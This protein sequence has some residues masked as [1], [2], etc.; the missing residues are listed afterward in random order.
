MNKTTRRGFIQQAATTIAGLALC[1]ST[2]LAK[3]RPIK[4]A[5]Y[6]PSHCAL[7][8]VHAYYSD[9]YKKNGVHAEIV[10]CAGMPEV[11]QK[12]ISGQVDFAQVMTPM[13][14]KMHFSQMNLPLVITQTLGTN[15]GALGVA[16]QS[17]I[18]KI[19][20]LNGKRIGI[21][22]PLMIHHLILRLILE[23]YGLTK[24]NIQIVTVPM[25][26]I[27]SSLRSGATQAFIHPEPLPTF[28][29]SQNIARSLLLT[30]MFWNNHPCCSL[31]CK[32]SFFEK[33]QQLVEDFTHATIMAGLKLDNIAM[34]Q[35]EIEKVH[36]FDTP[37]KKFPLDRLQQAFQPRRSDFYPFPFLS[38]GYVVV[39]QMKKAQLL[40]QTIDTKKSVKN[41]IQADLAMKILKNVAGH[42][43]GTSVPTSNERKET[44]QLI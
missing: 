23:K 40:P 24:K 33:N 3:P 20:D 29:E 8:V 44:F 2:I 11:T 32:R 15:G 34:R 26:Q 13:V 38:A 7:P 12:L 39:E 43:P 18:K 41:V 4:I 30:R 37:F 17:K 35:S 9:L 31:A 10:H 14:F 22:N 5:I 42:I 1:P 27:E 28:M 25:N 21:H 16:S 36:S 19:Q 6:A